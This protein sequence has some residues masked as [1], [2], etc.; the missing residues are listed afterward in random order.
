MAASAR[1]VLGDITNQSKQAAAA[2]AGKR[3]RHHQ[4]HLHVEREQDEDE[5]EDDDADVSVEMMTD[6]P[7][8]DTTAHDDDAETE[9]ADA[10]VSDVDISLDQDELLLSADKHRQKQQQHCDAAAEEQKMQLASSRSLPSSA[11]SASS[12]LVPSAGSAASSPPAFAF[13]ASRFNCCLS[14]YSPTL[15]SYLLESDVRSLPCSDYMTRT[16]HDLSFAMRSIL[17][18]W[19][20]DVSHEYALHCHT[21]LLTARHIDRFLSCFAISRSHLQ[22]LGIACMLL[23]AKCWEVRP[24]LVDDFVYISD[25]TY[26]RDEVVRM[27]RRVLTVLRWEVAGCSA[28]DFMRLLAWEMAQTES[29]GGGGGEEE[30]RMAQMLMEMVAMEGD[31]AVAMRAATIGVS[32]L[33]VARW[34]L[35][36]QGRSQWRQAW[37]RAVRILGSRSESELEGCVRLMWRLWQRLKEQQR[38]LSSDAAPLSSSSSPSAAL[39]AMCAGGLLMKGILNKYS[40]QQYGAVTAVPLRH[41]SPLS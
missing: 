24:P 25:N 40:K 37:E 27:E 9:D 14:D 1:I 35:T 13:S 5:E 41:G 29:G 16:Q 22:L 32:A 12:L 15:L 8:M 23:A 33:L 36:G 20:I 11:S 4:H 28:Y 10:T 31:A 19:L 21:L 18:D 30:E 38:L 39:T 17:L 2:A 3:H 6:A 7:P 26:T 34:A